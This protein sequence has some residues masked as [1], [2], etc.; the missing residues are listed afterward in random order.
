MKKKWYGIKPIV[1]VDFLNQ[2]NDLGVI[3]EYIKL[4]ST[5]ITQETFGIYSTTNIQKDLVWTPI[6]YIFYYHTEEIE[7]KEWK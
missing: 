1:V 2:L 4:A 7:E 5:M 6:T 3:P